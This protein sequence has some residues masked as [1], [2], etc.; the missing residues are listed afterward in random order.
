MKNIRFAIVFALVAYSAMSQTKEENILR[1]IEIRNEDRLA[2]QGFEMILPSFQQAY[3][4]VP[5]EM[6]QKIKEKIDTTEITATVI[7]IYSNHYTNE[8][9]LQLI[10]F[11]QTPIGKKLLS[12]SPSI[13]RESLEAGIAWGKRISLQIKQELQAQGYKDQ[14]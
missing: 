3:P 11:Y 12:E 6:W 13:L 5:Y 1:L 2:M 14:Y 10:E 8:E 9:I 7:Q 4:K